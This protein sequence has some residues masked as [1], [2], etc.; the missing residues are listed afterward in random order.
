MPFNIQY[1][2]Y[3][4]SSS[5]KKLISRLNN[6]GK[7][8]KVLDIPCG[9]GE[10]TFHLSK[11]KN[12]TIEGY[13]LDSKSIEHAVRT[14]KNANL[15]FYHGDIFTVLKSKSDMD[16]IC[17]INSFFL[18]PDRDLLLTMIKNA[19]SPDGNV[20]FIIPNIHG[21]NYLNFKKQSPQVNE[22]E[23]SVEEFESIL[24]KQGISPLFNKGICY[25]NVYGRK[26]LKYLSRLAP[27]YL[28]G[29]NYFLSGFKIGKPN[30]YL[31]GAKKNI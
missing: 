3:I 2:Q 19:L 13:D 17:V 10:T 31:I 16:V 11:L 5:I 18:L 4:F 12:I 24:R 20:F 28:M 7:I 23:L 8:L 26:E 14:Y 27:L 1:P 9:N 15:S 22:V 30:Y 21:K 25:V 6:D 29:I